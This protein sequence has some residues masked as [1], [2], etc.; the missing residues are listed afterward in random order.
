MHIEHRST[1][2]TAGASCA[3]SRLS[4]PPFS[5]CSDAAVRPLLP[6]NR[7][8]FSPR[9]GGSWRR[10]RLPVRRFSAEECGAKH[11]GRPREPIGLWQP[12]GGPAWSSNPRRLLFRVCPC[13]LTPPTRHGMRWRFCPLNPEVSAG[14]VNNFHSLWYAEICVTTSYCALLPRSPHPS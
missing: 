3:A 1:C 12:T 13:V 10:W 8:L 4:A 7:N 2:S 5:S 9:P 11:R 14:I 6:W